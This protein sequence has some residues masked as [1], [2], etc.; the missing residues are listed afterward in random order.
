MSA[1]ITAAAISVG[2]SFL[3]GKSASK[4]AQAAAEA[5]ARAAQKGID[6]QK[7]A[8][9]RITQL[10]NPYVKAGTQALGGVQ[11]LLGV[12][13]P[14]AQQAAIA[15]LQASPMFGSIV[16]QG[17]NAILQNA[18]ATGGLR[19]GNVQ[20]ALAKFRPSVLSDLINQQ[21]SRLGGLAQLGFQGATTQG[22]AE[23]QSAANIANL[24]TQKGQA[25]AGGLLAQAA[26]MANLFQTIGGL[27]GQFLG[28]GIGNYFKTGGFLPQQAPQQS[29]FNVNQ[30][31][32]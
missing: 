2:G 15:Q 18:A 16:Q 13:T 26:P 30:M 12:T 7:A 10:F 8:L 23:Q 9:D 28:Q 29:N 31:G 1:A 11:D 17:E 3:S 22:T 4:G 27:G 32:F 24:L 6:E 21:Y 20:A 19:G 14:E 25:Q 5:Q